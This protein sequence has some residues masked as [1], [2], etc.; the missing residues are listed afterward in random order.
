MSHPEFYIRACL[1][2][3]TIPTAPPQSLPTPRGEGLLL[4]IKSM[5]LG[6]YAA[7]FHAFYDLSLGIILLLSVNL[8]FGM[9]HV[10]PLPLP[11]T[12]KVSDSQGRKC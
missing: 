8:K 12:S 3:M 4:I 7:Q 5:K 2:P 10:F 1:M 11:F 6:G 9:T